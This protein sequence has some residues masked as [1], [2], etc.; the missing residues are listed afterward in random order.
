MDYETEEG[1]TS[2]LRD[3]STVLACMLRDHEGTCYYVELEDS[4]ESALIFTI[5]PDLVKQG[6][7]PSTFLDSRDFERMGLELVWVLHGPLTEQ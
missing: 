4:S 1:M 7:F 6:I 5:D 2:K 3:D